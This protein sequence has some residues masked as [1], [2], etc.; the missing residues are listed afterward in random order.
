MKKTITIETRKKF[1][2]LAFISLW[3]VG[4][5]LFWIYPLVYSLFMSLNKVTIMTDHLQFDF[6]GFAN[7]KKALTQDAAI[8]N[9]FL[10]FIQQT[11]LII[12]I[13]VVFSL[14]IA[15]L[16]NQKFKGR[17][18]I[19]GIF[20]LPVVLTSGNL[21]NTLVGQKQGSISFLVSVTARDT[22]SSLGPTWGATVNNI[23]ANFLIILWYSGVQMLIL[24]AGLQSISP[25]VYEAA[26]ID[27]ANGWEA[28][29]KITL[30]G[31]T[32]FIFIST[33]YTIVDQFTL[34]SNP[35]LKIVNDTIFG[36]NM[37][38]GYASAISWLYFIVITLFLAVSFLIF[39]NS[40]RGMRR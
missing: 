40:L 32:P 34:T 13:I 39:R 33:V 37:G 6:V 2:G 30:P 29:W 1:V 18:L 16:L 10:Q 23:L 5:I 21:I 22:F 15:L 25:S 38:F 3:L 27:G 8:P 24:I 35:I 7:F 4:L 20:F 17:G 28:L 31:I 36:S 14:I 9:T 12:P 26:K 11:V 19:R